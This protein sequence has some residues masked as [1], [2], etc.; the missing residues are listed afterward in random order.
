MIEKG[1]LEEA[2]ILFNK[3]PN[4]RAL[5]TAIG[6]KEL[7][8]YFNNEITLDEAIYQIKINSRHYA[9]RQYTWFNHQLDV[10]WFEVDFDDFNKTINSVKLYIDKE[11]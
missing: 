6:Y 8:K 1:L 4:S 7:F 11:L 2:K 10:N 5:N 3:Y 9:K